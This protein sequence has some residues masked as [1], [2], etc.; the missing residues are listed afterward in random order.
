[1]VGLE[2]HF[3]KVACYRGV[4]LQT[5][6]HTSIV[7]LKLKDISTVVVLTPFE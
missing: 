2:R 6:A 7:E 4:Q 1:M 3:N 5:S